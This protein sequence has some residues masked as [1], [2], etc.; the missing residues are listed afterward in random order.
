[1]TFNSGIVTNTLRLYSDLAHWWPLFSPPSHYVEEAADLIPVLLGATDTPPQTMLEL[2]AGGGSLAN[3]LK[4]HL[5][6]TLTDRSAEMLAVS[7]AVNPECEHLLG[8]MTSVELGRQF[9]L[10]LIHDA[11]MYATDRDAARATIRTAYKHCRRGGAVILVPDHVRETF[12]PGT[13]T[14][15]EDAP[16]GRGLRYIEWIWDPDFSDDTYEVTFAFLLREADGHVIVEAERHRVGCFARADW[17]KWMN[18][19]GFTPRFRID[20]WGREMFV[21]TTHDR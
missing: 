16:D 18:E 12:S 15:G 7:Q 20:P 17:L 5:T 6:L 8:D 9:D 11:I 21:G 19:A 4:H 10:V 3:H 14:G 1:M 13:H 2:G